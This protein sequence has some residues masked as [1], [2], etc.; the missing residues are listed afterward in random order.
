MTRRR[1]PNL[2]RPTGERARVSDYNIRND[3]M[4]DIKEFYGWSEQK[5]EQAVR[6]DAIDAPRKEIE[7]RYKQAYSQD[8]NK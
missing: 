5:L 8:K 3:S 2:S 7:V 1:V 4:K 6:G